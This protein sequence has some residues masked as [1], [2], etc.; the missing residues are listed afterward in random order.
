[1]WGLG[2]VWKNEAVHS[3]LGCPVGEQTGAEGEELYFQNGY[4]LWRPDAGLIYVFFERMQPGGW[5]AF[6][7]TF[8]PTDP[9]TDPS[10]MVPTPEPGKPIYAQ[11]T[12]RFGKLWRESAWL[13]DK[14]GW[15]VAAHVEDQTSPVTRFTGALQ[16]FERGVLYWNGATCFVLR[17]D[18]MS[19]DM[20]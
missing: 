14:L 10:V 17:M 16:D 12:G 1:M 4:M 5:G 11:P 9:D 2:D 7:D 3:R 18:D 13:R 6:L 15:A 20:Y 19:W 8:Q